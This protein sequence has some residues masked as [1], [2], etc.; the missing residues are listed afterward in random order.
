M[1][2]VIV[3]RALAR[4]MVEPV[5][6]GGYSIFLCLPLICFLMLRLWCLHCGLNA[7]VWVGGCAGLWSTW[8]LCSFF[9]S[10]ESFYG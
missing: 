7:G 9:A 10:A 6:A 8:Q 2:Q 5:W 1:V 4:L 3:Q